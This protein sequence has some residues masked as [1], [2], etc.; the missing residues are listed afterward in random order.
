[1]KALPF[2]W[3][4]AINLFH[5]I[6]FSV[7]LKFFK[8]FQ[9]TL[10]SNKWFFFFKVNIFMQTVQVR[11]FRMKLFFFV[12]DTCIKLKLLSNNTKF[13]FEL[14]SFCLPFQ[15]AETER[16]REIDQN[17]KTVDWLIKQHLEWLYFKFVIH[18]KK[19]ILASI[20]TIDIHS[21]AK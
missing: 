5:L 8:K 14:F 4:A 2:F 16:E 3:W 20:N 19:K 11:T 18:L 10:L 17:W 6:W 13:K 1:M 7:S 9:D 15:K 21:I 12:W